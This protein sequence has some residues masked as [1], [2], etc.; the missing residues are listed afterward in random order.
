MS[1]M[2]IAG[3]RFIESCFV[4]RQDARSSASRYSAFEMARNSSI[5]RWL[6]ERLRTAMRK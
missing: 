3:D 4:D 1:R 2:T 6:S 5:N